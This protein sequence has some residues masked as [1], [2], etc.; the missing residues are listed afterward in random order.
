LSATVFR[1]LVMK[2]ILL[3]G[4]R[5]IKDAELQKQRFYNIYS[6][7]KRRGT[8]TKHHLRETWGFHIGFGSSAVFGT[9]ERTNLTSRTINDS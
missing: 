9:G 1:T 7:P 8:R 5:S 3:L 4:R 6:L 2:K